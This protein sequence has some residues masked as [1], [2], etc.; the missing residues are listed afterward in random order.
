MQRPSNKQPASQPS[1]DVEE[2]PFTM[3]PQVEVILWSDAYH[4]HLRPHFE[5]GISEAELAALDRAIARIEHRIFDGKPKQA[6][7]A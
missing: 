7:S 4:G 3:P 1:R 2:T 5:G 6:L